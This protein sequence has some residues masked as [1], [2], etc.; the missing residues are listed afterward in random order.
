LTATRGSDYSPA[1]SS[2]PEPFLEPL[3]LQHI[4]QEQACVKIFLTLMP[5]KDLCLE[6]E[7][8]DPKYT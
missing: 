6:H 1:V 3:Q 5:D 4:A 2:S 8:S 7:A